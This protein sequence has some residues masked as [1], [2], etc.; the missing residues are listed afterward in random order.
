MCGDG[1]GGLDGGGRGTQGLEAG[2]T[3][4]LSFCIVL[5]LFRALLSTTFYIYISLKLSILAAVLALYSRKIKDL[6]SPKRSLFPV[7]CRFSFAFYA[8]QKSKKT[9]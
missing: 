1:R 7:T 2:F 9:I 6:I 4:F 3:G 8:L 5:F